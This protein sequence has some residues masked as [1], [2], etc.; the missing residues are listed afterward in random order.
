MRNY[1]FNLSSK[2]LTAKLIKKYDVLLLVTNHDY[3][4]YE[5]I[6]KNANT[7]VDT[8]GVYSKKI[9]NVVSA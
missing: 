9:K 3:F 8:R 4:D 5:F 6:Q 7:I 2:T 1:K